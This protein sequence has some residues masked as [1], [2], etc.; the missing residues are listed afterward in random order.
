MNVTVRHLKANSAVVSW[1]VL[2]D[3]VVIGFAISQQV[4][5]EGPWEGRTHQ[6]RSGGRGR[7]G[8]RKRKEKGTRSKRDG[9][10]AA[11]VAGKGGPRMESFGWNLG[12][13]GMILILNRSEFRTLLQFLLVVW[14]WAISLTS[15][16][17]SPY[18]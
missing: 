18:L 7:K 6:D 15:V 11:H 16:N 5:L 14:P 8:C 17:L 12:I 10:K 2:E 13:K 3:E 1:D 4:T 9:Q